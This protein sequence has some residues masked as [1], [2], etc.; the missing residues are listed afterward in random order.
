MTARRRRSPG[1]RDT[2]PVRPAGRRRRGR[3]LLPCWW[4]GSGWPCR[5]L[6][7]G[8]GCWPARRPACCG[9][10]SA[11]CASG[12][13]SWPAGP[14]LGLFVPGLWWVTS[15]NTYGGLVLM[16]ARGPGPGPG[17]RRGP[18]PRPGAHGRAGRAMV[19]AEALRSTWPFGGLP[20]A[21]SPWARRGPLA[22]AARLGGPLL[23]VGLVWLG[24]GGLA[25]GA[26]SP[27][28]STRARRGTSGRGPHRRVA[29]AVARVARAWRAVAVGGWPWR[30]AGRAAPDGGRPSRHLRVAAVQGGGARGLRKS[31]VDPATRLPP[32][33]SRPREILAG[34]RRRPGP[35]T[36]GVARGR[37]VARRPHRR[38]A[39]RDSNLAR[40]AGSLHA[41]FT[42][43]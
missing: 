30:R 41:T 39:G 40:L 27:P 16:V 33:S 15:F 35:D 29:G 37:G 18:A 7:G 28:R 3:V 31:E 20:W 23:L 1:R 34:A 43:G 22:G 24:G 36:G 9:G 4:P 42:W 21:A 14:G 10:G 12:R 6:P 32:P 13:A 11:A 2:R 17:L 26:L 19:L 25:L 38:H 8:S 5:S